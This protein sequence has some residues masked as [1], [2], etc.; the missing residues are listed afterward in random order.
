MASVLKCILSFLIIN[1]FVL[2]AGPSEIRIGTNE[3]RFEWARERL[4][5]RAREIYSNGREYTEVIA[6]ESTK[7]MESFHDLSPA[8]KIELTKRLVEMTSA[9]FFQNKG[10]LGA[11]QN[12]A[13][14]EM[15]LL[16]SG[17]EIIPLELVNVNELA[18]FIQAR[19]TLLRSY[20]ESTF[21]S[22]SLEILPADLLPVMSGASSAELF[23][24]AETINYCRERAG[25]ARTSSQKVFQA[26]FEQITS[27]YA[28]PQRVGQ[29]QVLDSKVQEMAHIQLVIGS[30]QEQ[31]RRG[32]EMG[33]NIDLIENNL[34]S[35][36]LRYEQLELELSPPSADDARP[37]SE[38]KL[39]E[40]LF[41]GRFSGNTGGL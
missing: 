41:L 7:L 8:A 25:L 39:E 40:E 38:Q 10:E 32:T 15:I 30:L 35:A 14:I 5:S 34:R 13:V 17:S 18:E 22:I 12:I 23:D 4:G 37:S 3:V 6:S 24:L 33:Q 1:S 19:R 16:S 11:H 36:I 9:E 21:D 27:R 29:V 28:D 20:V 26:V 2:F 31:Q